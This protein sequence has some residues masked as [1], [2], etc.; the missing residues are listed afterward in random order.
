MESSP[1]GRDIGP[2]YGNAASIVSRGNAIT[3]LGDQM[4]TSAAMLESIADGASGQ[5][6]L[7]VEKLQEVV[8][9]CYEELK[10]AGERYQPTGP[11]LVT[12]GTVIAEVQPLIRTVVQNCEEAWET[13]QTRQSAV[14]SAQTAYYPAPPA[15]AGEDA[16]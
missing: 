13:Y 3:T 5:E 10:L 11:V 15:D 4:I 16:D 12:Y 1:K 8:G 6:G 2:L 9:D 14:W 7:A